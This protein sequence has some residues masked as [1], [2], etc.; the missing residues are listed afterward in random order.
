LAVHAVGHAFVGEPAGGGTQAV[1]A[2]E[3]GGDAD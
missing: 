2:V 1:E 3:G